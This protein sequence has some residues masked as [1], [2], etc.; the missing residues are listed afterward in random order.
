MCLAS[1]FQK[2]RGCC[3]LLRGHER[4]Y[5]GILS[6][7][8]LRVWG[9]WTLVSDVHA[10]SLDER[11]RLHNHGK[12][13]ATWLVHGGQSDKVLILLDFSQS[14]TLLAP[15]NHARSEYRLC[16]TWTCPGSF[17]CERLA[18]RLRTDLNNWTRKKMR[19]LVPAA[20]GDSARIGNIKSSWNTPQNIPGASLR[21]VVQT[22][23]RLRRS[24]VSS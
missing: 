6:V 16:V 1:Y 24:C 10:H 23:I 20:E 5:S 4:Q 13:Q 22:A 7:G 2:F 11:H 12:L 3:A 8:F 19:I 21:L 17:W 15:P 14:S 18:I 9:D